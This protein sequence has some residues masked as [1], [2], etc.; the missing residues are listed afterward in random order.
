MLIRQSEG[1]GPCAHYKRRVHRLRLTSGKGAC[2]RTLGSV[3]RSS[4]LVGVAKREYSTELKVHEDHIQMAPYQ[5][6][7]SSCGQ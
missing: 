3:T 2:S 5:Q 1:S 7:E 6:C 4:G